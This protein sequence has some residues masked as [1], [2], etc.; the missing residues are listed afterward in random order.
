MKKFYFFIVTIL[1][2]GQIFAQSFTKNF[3]RPAGCAGSGA[4]V[5]N[6][7]DEVLLRVDEPEYIYTQRVKMEVT[8]Q[9]D[10]TGIHFV[11]KDGKMYPIKK[12]SIRWQKVANVDNRY[13][14]G[15]DFNWNHYGHLLTRRPLKYLVAKL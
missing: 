1:F 12:L 6:E 8:F 9:K 13:L 10:S 15:E 5:N 11:A 2:T 4:I 7:T 3:Y 14:A